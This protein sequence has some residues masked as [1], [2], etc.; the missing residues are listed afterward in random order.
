MVWLL[1]WSVTYFMAYTVSVNGQRMTLGDAIVGIAYE[2][3][4]YTSVNYDQNV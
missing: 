3:L 1:A 4:K 2:A